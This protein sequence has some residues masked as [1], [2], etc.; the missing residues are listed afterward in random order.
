[1]SNHPRKAIRDKI[2]ELIKGHTV[3]GD[4]VQANRVRPV[5]ESDL[6]KILVYTREEPADN[7]IARD[8][9]PVKRDL[10]LVVECLQKI[11]S[12]LDDELDLMCGQV[13]EVLGEDDTLDGLVNDLQYTGVSISRQREGD[14]LMGSAALSYDCNYFTRQITGL[15]I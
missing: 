12:N 15:K 8:E 5:N 13:E 7:L 3:A 2:V 6:P 1:M 4:N 9:L 10:Q 14:Q 11:S